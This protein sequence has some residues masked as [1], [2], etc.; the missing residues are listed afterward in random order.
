MQ[1]LSRIFAFCVCNNICEMP[2]LFIS[3]FHRRLFLSFSDETGGT[4][5]HETSCPMVSCLQPENIGQILSE[6]VTEKLYSVAPAEGNK[7]CSVFE[8]ESKAFPYLIPNGKNGHDEERNSKIG[9]N[10]YFNLRLFSADTRFASDPQYIFYSQYASELHYVKNSI[11]IA[12]RKSSKI[13]PDN[14]NVTAAML[15][16]VE[17]RKK[18]IRSD[19]GYRFLKTV[20]GTPPY[21]EKTLLDLFGMLRQL[22]TPTWFCSF[23]AAD[24][25]WPEI[26][27]AICKQQGR[28]VPD[29]MDWTTHCNIINSNPVTAC[30]M[31][32][33]RV[34]NFIHAVILSPANPIGHVTDFFY[35]TEFQSRGWPHIHCLFWCEN[36]P[37][38]AKKQDNTSMSSFI[39]QYVT[40]EMPDKES[41]VYDI[42]NSVQMHSKN[43]SKSCKKGSKICRF[44]FPRPPSMRTFIAEKADPPDDVPIEVYQKQAKDVLTSVWNEIQKDNSDDITALS[45][46]FAKVGISQ[47]AYE[48]AHCALTKRNVVIYKRSVEGCWIN[49]YN[50]HLLEAWDGNM[51]IQPVLDP[52]SCIMYIV[53]Y[54]TKSER[55]QGDL[56]RKAQREAAEGNTEPLKLLQKL[57]NIYLTHREISIM[58]AIYRVTGMKLKQSSRE[59]IFVPTD[60]NSVRISKPLHLIN[61]EMDDEDLWMTN[62]VDR[63]LARPEEFECMCL[64]EFASQYKVTYTKNSKSKAPLEDTGEGDSETKQPKHVYQLQNGMGSITKRQKRAVVRYPHFNKAKDSERYYANLLKMYYPHR[65]TTIDPDL[66][67]EEL[68]LSEKQIILEN[69]AQFERLTED[70]DEAWEQLKQQGHKKTH[71]LKLP[72][73]PKLKGLT[74]SLKCYNTLRTLKKLITMTPMI[75]FLIWMYRVKGKSILLKSHIT[76]VV[77]I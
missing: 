4:E 6:D 29:N 69:M 77:S 30:R 25:R 50:I 55:E 76:V 75:P 1:R 44:N 58:E 12:L 34:I 13:T 57:G 51:D 72:Q 53:G 3:F 27:E 46:I 8:M 41:V 68:F 39:D 62:V 26:C 54:I 9:L 16:D 11:S 45:E 48:K 65:T 21:W 23:S 66:S 64:A 20:R 18:I 32:E 5:L 15:K 7:P 17:E 40:A 33:H 52:E 43:H 31:F 14:A 60:P 42:V 47:E 38:F 24:R 22:G 61:D 73:I 71:G 59:V 70:L 35:R 2:M 28:E 49:P 67:Y 19:L 56:L 36:A 74:K 10:R 37:K 63:Y